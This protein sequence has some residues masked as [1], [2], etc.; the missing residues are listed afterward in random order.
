MSTDDEAGPLLEFRRSMMQQAWDELM[1]DYEVTA[2]KIGDV[3]VKL[4]LERRN[5]NFTVR[6]LPIE[7]RPLC[8]YL[9]DLGWPGG[10]ED[11]E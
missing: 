2:G 6:D 8:G 1:A 4:D 9:V 5:P 7:V 10:D 3:C 11:P